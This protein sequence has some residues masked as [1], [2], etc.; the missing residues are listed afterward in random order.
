[1]N[2]ERLGAS[3]YRFMLFTMRQI[4]LFAAAI[5]LV[6]CGNQPKPVSQA[7]VPA[8]AQ[9][10]GLSEAAAAETQVEMVNVNIHL[11]NELILHIRRLEGRFLPT[12][13]G[14]PPTFDDNLSYIVVIDSGEVAVSLASMTHAMNTYVFGEPDAP[15]KNLRLSAEGSQIRQEGTLKKGPGVHF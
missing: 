7:P 5:L 1:M 10:A 14:Q 12:R 2:K 13:K 15:L 4:P 6:S 3:D 11:D 8:A 9:L